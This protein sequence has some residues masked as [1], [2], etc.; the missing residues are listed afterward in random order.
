MLGP[1]T[2]EQRLQTLKVCGNLDLVIEVI[3]NSGALMRRQSWR[4]CHREGLV[5]NKVDTEWTWEVEFRK[6]SL[7]IAAFADNKQRRPR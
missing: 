4:C 3:F 7:A 1:Q 6:V 2:A 5:D